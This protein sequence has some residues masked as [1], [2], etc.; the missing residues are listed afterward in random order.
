MRYF[1]V[2]IIV[3]VATAP[4]LA[5]TGG[6]GGAQGAGRAQAMGRNNT[7]A[8]DPAKKKAEER[9]FNDAVKRI[10]ASDKKFDPWGN[11]RELP[12]H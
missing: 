7:P 11:V 9:A 5:Q 4:A 10:P 2:A 12:K 6:I 8:E 1:I 3:A